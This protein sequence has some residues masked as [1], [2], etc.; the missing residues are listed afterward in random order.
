MAPFLGALAIFA[1]VVIAIVSFNIFGR[2][3]TPE[4]Q[5][6]ARAVVGQNDALQRRD[7]ADFRDYTCRAQQ[8]TESEVLAQQDDSVAKRGHRTVDDVTD[9]RIDGDV[10][11]DK[12]TAKVTYHFDSD[13]AAKVGVDTT[14]MREDGSWKVCSPGPR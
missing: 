5:R 6:V 9:V 10:D 12:A 13:S 7:Y 8:S 2:D 4:D 11:G 3:N 1:L 14:F